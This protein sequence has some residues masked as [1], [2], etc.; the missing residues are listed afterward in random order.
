MASELQRHTP[1]VEELTGIT[2]TL[3]NYETFCLLGY[4][5]IQNVVTV[6]SEEH[7]NST[8]IDEVDPD[9]EMAG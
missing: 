4:S 6:I 2:T 3:P 9:E 1:C 7:V 8:S 5:P